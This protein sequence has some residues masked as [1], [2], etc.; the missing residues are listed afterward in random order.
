MTIADELPFPDGP[1]G[2]RLR[3]VLDELLSRG[4]AELPHVAGVPGIH[5][6]Q[7]LYRTWLGSQRAY[8]P[9][10]H[11]DPKHLAGAQHFS[12]EWWTVARNGWIYL[13]APSHHE[14]PASL[15]AAI[16][17]KTLFL[18]CQ[19]ENLPWPVTPEWTRGLLRRAPFHNVAVDPSLA[20]LRTDFRVRCE[21]LDPCVQ[22]PQGKRPRASNSGKCH[23]INFAESVHIK[24]A[25][26]G[27]SG[28]AVV[29]R[30]RW[31]ILGYHLAI[32]VICDVFI[33][34]PI[35]ERPTIA[36]NSPPSLVERTASAKAL[37]QSF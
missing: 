28:S 24:R 34:A 10:L 12:P 3:N 27:P 17:S 25:Q 8:R 6:A 9:L 21:T 13:E 18:L 23:S 1:T 30:R 31:V 7:W 22:I 5:V 15:N 37:L 11:L 4:H 32:R 26:R 2:E 20:Y 35:R 19:G 29:H 36:P 14:R 16:A 33:A